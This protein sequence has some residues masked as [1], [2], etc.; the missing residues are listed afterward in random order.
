MGNVE[1]YETHLQFVRSFFLSNPRFALALSNIEKQISTKNLTFF[2]RINVSMFSRHESESE[3]I[4][5]DSA[6]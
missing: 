2:L 1:H 5:N 4:L 6:F 3:G